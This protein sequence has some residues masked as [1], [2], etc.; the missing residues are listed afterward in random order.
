MT[1]DK[2]WFR[3]HWI[4]TTL[5][6][7]ILISII[8]SSLSGGDNI[9]TSSSSSSSSPETTIQITAVELFREYKKNEISADAKYEGKL[10]EVNGTVIALGKDIFDSPYVQFVSE[11]GGVK[12]NSKDSELS[13]IGELSRGDFIT[14]RGRGDGFLIDADIKGCVIVG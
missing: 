9:D 3:R 1:K 7:I 2:S 5:G 6:V 14:V 11:F 13:K 8:S 12:C 4:L 10:L